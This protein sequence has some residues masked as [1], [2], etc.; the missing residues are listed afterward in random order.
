MM[1]LSYL[2]LLKK[3]LMHLMTLKWLLCIKVSKNLCLRKYSERHI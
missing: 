1:V 3:D 2:K